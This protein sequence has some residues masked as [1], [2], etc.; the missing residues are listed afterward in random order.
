M[1]FRAPRELLGLIARVRRALRPDDELIM[2]AGA[3]GELLVAKIRLLVAVLLL[4][5]PFSNTLFAPLPTQESLVGLTMSVSTVVLA[6]LVYLL[7]RRD[8]YVPWLGFATSICDVTAVSF[9]LGIFL[10]LGQP[11]T[12]VNSK[13][14]FEVYFLALAA[15]CLRYDVRICL[16]AGALAVVQYA[17]LVTWTATHYD[18]N[19]PQ[20]AP[21]A[22]GMFSW[23][24]QL[25]RIIL[26]VCGA[27]MSAAIVFRG[28][29]LRRLSTLDRMTGVAN[30][31]FFDERV[32]AELSRRTR[33]QQPMAIVMVDVDHFKAF[34]DRY[35]HGPG[36]AA[37]RTL[38]AA[39][40]RHLRRSDLV[41]RYGGEEF[42]LL[43]PETTPADAFEKMEALRREI[44]R[45]PVRLSRTELAPALTVSMGIASAPD[46][47][48]QG[49][50]LLAAADARL[51]HAKNF[52]RNMTVGA[53]VRSIANRS[54]E[55]YAQR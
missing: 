50:V 28:R 51:F 29:D 9:T 13:V 17:G 1:T 47:G 38:A 8:R 22:Y 32:A 4:L 23:A 11:H 37:L 26:L 33:T 46:D 19:G 35:G 25:N 44:S 3:S 55:V 39:M 36:D 7:V 52:G 24:A 31:G 16:A 15:T 2:D 34:N 27:A 10:L 21:Y 42:V 12:V 48:D 45:T 40:R 43:L 18:L 30:R 53:G 6:S 5:I 41:A 20:Y 54:G 49:D 14:V